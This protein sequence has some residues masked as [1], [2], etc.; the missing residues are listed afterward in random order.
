M[1]KNYKENIPN[2]SQKNSQR[3]KMDNHQKIEKEKIMNA[4]KNYKRNLDKKQLLYRVPDKDSQ[5]KLRNYSYYTED[6]EEKALTRREKE[7]Y[8]PDVIIRD[9][10]SPYYPAKPACSCGYWTCIILTVIF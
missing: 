5:N 4:L 7:Q 1:V 2:E 8:D 6:E 3:E 9:Y 10:N